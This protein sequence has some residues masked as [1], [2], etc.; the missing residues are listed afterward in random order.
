M[1]KSKRIAGRGLSG[2]TGVIKNKRGGKYKATITIHC[3]IQDVVFAP[4]DLGS[5]DTAKQA[6]IVYD[7]EAIR[8]RQ[9]LSTLNFPTMAPVGYTTIQQSN[10][11]DSTRPI[12]TPDPPA[13]AGKVYVVEH[14]APIASSPSVTTSVSVSSSSSSWGISS[15]R[16][17]HEFDAYKNIPPELLRKRNIEICPLAQPVPEPTGSNAFLMAALKGHVEVVRL[18]LQQPNIELN[19]KSYGKSPLG[20]ATQMNHTE[21][22]QLLTDAGAQ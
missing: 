1:P 10:F 5:Y 7:K 16:V 11:H 22:I 14:L 9:P 20:W 15:D 3:R 17:I 6:A 21:I 12:P 4:K 19:K 13:Y 2:Y 8:L 18:L